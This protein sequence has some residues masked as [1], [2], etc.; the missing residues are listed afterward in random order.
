MKYLQFILFFTFLAVFVNSVHGQ[1][2]SVD[3]VPEHANLS[4]DQFPMKGG[5]AETGSGYVTVGDERVMNPAAWSISHAGHKAVFLE[6]SGESLKIVQ[7][8][9][10][11][12][13]LIDRELQFFDTNDETLEIYSFDDGRSVTRDNVANFTFFDPYGE[14]LYSISNSSQSREGELESRLATDS[15]GRTVV[16]YNPVISFGDTRGSS[17][18][19]VYGEE[20]HEIFYRDQSAEIVELKVSENGSFITVL[21]ATG[22]GHELHLYD[23]FGNS[24]NQFSFDDPLIGAN[25]SGDGK[26]LTV[27][28]RGRIQVLNTLTGERIGSTSSRSPVLFAAYQPDDDL[29]LSL[30]GNIRGSRLTEPE[31]TAVHIGQRQIVREEVTG[32][33]SLLNRGRIQ[34]IR[35][36]PNEYRVEGLN[37]SLQ[38]QAIF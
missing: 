13:K 10:S 25:L 33:L 27:Y 29:I 1:Q 24:L 8:D 3:S 4:R 16:L 23:R 20:N 5:V 2:L 19:L 26:F 18:R 32:Q 6:P 11:G 38:V 9:G 28:S 36:Q 7:M 17:A 35:L 14:Q 22:S 21:S 12:N 37:R 15:S 34:I 30:G 31:I